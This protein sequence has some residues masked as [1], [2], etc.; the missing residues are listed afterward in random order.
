MVVITG[1]GQEDHPE[2]P[3]WLCKGRGSA[4]GGASQTPNQRAY[5]EGAGDTVTNKTDTAGPHGA[6]EV[7]GEAEAAQTIMNNAL[8]NG[9][10]GVSWQGTVRGTGRAGPQRLISA[11][12]WEGSARRKE[13]A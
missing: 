5:E 9:T 11:G 4:W 7:Y 6:P 8:N 13:G 3:I 12:S 10:K 1:E 2:N